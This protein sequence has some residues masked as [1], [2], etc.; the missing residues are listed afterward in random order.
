[1]LVTWYRLT[2][3]ISRCGP[4]GP[5]MDI[6]EQAKQIAQREAQRQAKTARKE[7]G[8]IIVDTTSEVFPEQVKAR[9][10]KDVARGVL[11]GLGI[12]YLLRYVTE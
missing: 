9:R 5:R 11:A 8:R 3:A 12:G 6:P 10:R 2:T 1:M 7:L 4:Y